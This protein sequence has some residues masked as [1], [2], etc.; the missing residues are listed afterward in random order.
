MQNNLDIDLTSRA[1]TFVDFLASDKI[2]F[3]FYSIPDFHQYAKRGSCRHL[4]LS[5]H[6][7]NKFNSI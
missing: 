1:I 3:Y 4:I 6:A 7:M 2:V 5:G